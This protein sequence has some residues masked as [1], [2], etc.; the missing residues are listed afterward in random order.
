MSQYCS[1][2]EKCPE[3]NNYKRC[4]KDSHFWSNSFKKKA[5]SVPAK[6]KEDVTRKHYVACNKNFFDPI[7]TLIY[8]LKLR[9]LVVSLE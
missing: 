5:L 1:R 3:P 8:F 6:A 4:T 7:S 9:R 2:T